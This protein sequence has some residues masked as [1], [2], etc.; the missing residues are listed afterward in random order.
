MC[1]LIWALFIGFA[2]VSAD[3]KPGTRYTKIET[4]SRWGPNAWNY[5]VYTFWISPTFLLLA[6][7]SS[8]S[9][10]LVRFAIF[11]EVSTERSAGRVHA[12]DR[13]RSKYIL[14]NIPRYAESRW[15]TDKYVMQAISVI[16]R[17]LYNSGN[18]Y[19]RHS[20]LWNAKRSN[21][22]C[23]LWT[24]TRPCLFRDFTFIEIVR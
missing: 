2:I 7:S 17:L 12:C 20:K 3:W 8:C 16:A 23:E 1:V 4:P 11:T 10:A 22:N 14:I 9:E 18:Q 19:Y 24:G 21:S 13:F 6:Y 15:L 5:T